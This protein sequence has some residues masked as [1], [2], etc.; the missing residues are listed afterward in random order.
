M[1][2]VIPDADTRTEYDPR[3]AATTMCEAFQHTAA[4]EPDAIALRSSDSKLELTWAQYAGRVRTLAAGLASVGLGRGDTVALLIGNRPEFHLID[5]ASFHLGAIPFSIYNTSSPEQIAHLMDNA[6]NRVIV[7]ESS[8]LDRILVARGDAAEPSTIVLL[9]GTGEGTITLD[10]LERR[11][12]V[13]DGFDFDA[14]WRAVE[15]EDVLTLIYTSGTTGPPKGVEL[16]HA[17]LLADCRATAAVLPVRRGARTT[18]Y[19]PH[20][21]IAD[22]WASHYNSIVYGIQV[23]TVADPRTVAGVVA[24]LKPTIWGAVPRV[25]EKI[26]AALEAAV[27]ADSDESRRTATEGAIA[28]GIEVARLREAGEPIPEE[29]AARH[30]AAE[31]HVLSK[32]RAKLGLDEAEWIIVGAAPLT[33]SVYEFLAGIGLP[34]TELFGMSECACCVSTVLPAEAKFGAVGRALPGIEVALADDGE[35]L[36]RG[37]TIMRGYRN[38]PERTAETLDS[39]GYLHTGDIATIDEAGYIRIVDRKKELIISAG[40]KNMSPAN[41]ESELKAGSPLIGQA[42]TIGDGR[43]YNVALIVLDPD[44]AGAEARRLGLEGAPVSEIAAHP[45]VREAVQAGVARANERLSRVEQVKRFELLGD[46]WLPGGDELTPTMKL[47]RKPIA[48]KYAAVI[49]QLYSS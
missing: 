8:Y 31:E 21:H 23:T 48:A 45:A 10:E 32:L 13:N 49:E 43:P 6:A 37:A 18:S 17:N 7:A 5:T 12:A 35:L 34:V 9:D 44:A 36:V 2:A 28:T 24:S 22:R 11:G 40:G 16:T 47:K 3:V 15:P 19:L 14:A 25:V 30:A 38:D 39:D 33:R 46:E 27:A 41:I 20:A 26:K 42:A 4:V 1:S 29:L